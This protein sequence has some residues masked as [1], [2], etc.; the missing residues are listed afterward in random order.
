M[1][2]KNR[3]PNTTKVY[4]TLTRYN[5]STVFPG[6]R[7]S[8]ITRDTKLS[9]QAVNS[10]ITALTKSGM[11]ITRNSRKLPSGHVVRYYQQG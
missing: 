5:E 10:A 1:S 7:A 11:S 3:V 9:Y 4:N 6:V 2:N 8:K